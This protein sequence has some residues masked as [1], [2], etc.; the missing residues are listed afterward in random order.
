MEQKS[1]KV[2]E[3]CNHRLRFVTLI[4]R[5]IITA[6]RMKFKARQLL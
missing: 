6:E 2:G 4:K 1:G 3:F 5:I